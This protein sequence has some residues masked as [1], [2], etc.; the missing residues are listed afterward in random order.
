MVPEVKALVRSLDL[1]ACRALAAQALELTSP[2]A[3]RDLAKAFLAQSSNV[4]A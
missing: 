3:V 2:E 4:K 1:P